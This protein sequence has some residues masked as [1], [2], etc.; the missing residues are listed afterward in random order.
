MKRIILALALFSL[1]GCANL[2]NHIA[3]DGGFFGS[4]T[5]DYIVRNDS[6]GRIM[7]VWKLR[8]VFVD[9]HG[10]FQDEHGDAISIKGDFKMI[11][12][13]DHS[14]WDSYHEYHAEFENKTYQELYAKGE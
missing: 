5:G 6:G 14:T 12:V 4:Y 13:K 2:Q 9:Q 3:H 11:R 7:D 8:G 10:L 1:V